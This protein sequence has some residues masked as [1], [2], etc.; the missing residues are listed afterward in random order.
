M[1]T[2]DE[3][4]PGSWDIDRNGFPFF[5]YAGRLPSRAKMKNGE[6]ARLPEDPWFLLG[7]YQ[8]TLFTHVSGEY[9]IITGQRGWGRLNQGNKP[10]SG[11]NRSVLE[12][13]GKEYVLTGINSPSADP[14]ICTRLF[15][16]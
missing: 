14:H 9:E 15:G 6:S 1:N 10:N 2:S 8:L 11:K 13:E 3:Q 12:I 4:I 16:C 5:N 7:N